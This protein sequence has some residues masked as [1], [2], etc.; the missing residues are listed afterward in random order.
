MSYCRFSSDDFQCDVYVYED[1]AGGWTTCV[2]S[3]RRVYKEALPPEVEID[4]VDSWMER[5]KKVNKM[6]DESDLVPIGLEYDGAH[7]N[8]NT[9]GECAGTLK[10]LK[11]AGYNVPQ[12][13]IDALEE[14]ERES[15]DLP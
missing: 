5:Y 3:N 8:D 6:L 2:A 7:F 14:E 15:Q 11:A 4:D 1:C 12:Y 13:A 9:P 10:M